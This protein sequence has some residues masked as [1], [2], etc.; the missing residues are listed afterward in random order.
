[1][2][3]CWTG[4]GL[5]KAWMKV[6]VTRTDVAGAVF[7]TLGLDESAIQDAFV[8]CNY[9]KI[10]DLELLLSFMPLI[11]TALL[12]EE[13]VCDLCAI[14]LKALCIFFFLRFLIFRQEQLCCPGLPRLDSHVDPTV[15]FPSPT[16]TRLPYQTKDGMENTR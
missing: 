5:Y 11:I 16:V 6:R 2:T 14:D 12:L 10:V 4:S 8:C 15:V 7:W 1:M 9:D 13:V 3:G